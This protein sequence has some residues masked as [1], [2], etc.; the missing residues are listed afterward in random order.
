[1]MIVNYASS[2]INKLEALLTV[3]VRVIIYDHHVFLVQA[4]DRKECGF[5]SQPMKFKNNQEICELT[6]ASGAIFKTLYFLHHLHMG[7]IS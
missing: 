3:D 5:P 7:P 4:T 6:K 2:V 1:M